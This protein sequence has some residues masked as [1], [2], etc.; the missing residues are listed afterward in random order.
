[1]EC[2]PVDFMVCM[3]PVRRMVCGK[4]G[5]VPHSSTC[6]LG[7]LNKHHML[8]LC[9]DEGV[10]YRT[11]MVPMQCQAHDGCHAC[12]GAASRPATAVPGAVH[13]SGECRRMLRLYTQHTARRHADFDILESHM[14]ACTPVNESVDDPCTTQTLRN[15]QVGQPWQSTQTPPR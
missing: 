5:K 11:M 9:H 6:P 3:G 10:V 13:V 8:K 14:L 1:M 2:H 7:H 12:S 15:A 4:G